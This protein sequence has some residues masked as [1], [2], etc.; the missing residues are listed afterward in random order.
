MSSPKFAALRHNLQSQINGATAAGI[1]PSKLQKWLD[2]IVKFLPILLALLE[3]PDNP[4]PPAPIQAGAP[5]TT[6]DGLME[7]VEKTI[8]L[9][10]LTPEQQEKVLSAVEALSAFLT[11]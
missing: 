9:R 2:L 5:I 6:I 7:F 10:S 4:N 8:E 1:D 3:K 11:M